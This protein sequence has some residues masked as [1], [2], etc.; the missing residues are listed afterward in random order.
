MYLPKVE[1]VFW[2]FG[3]KILKKSEKE[4]AMVSIDKTHIKMTRGDTAVLILSMSKGG[5]TFSPADGDVITFTLKRTVK[6][7]EP[8][9]TKTAVG[10][11]IKIEPI[12]T[13]SLEFG[14][15]VYDIAITYENGDVDTFVPYSK[16]TLTEEVG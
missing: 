10:N 2:D 1:G 6:D 13:E 8:L 7:A 15:Y 14:T 12:D 5:F 3:Q 9:I 16:L 11:R 4:Y